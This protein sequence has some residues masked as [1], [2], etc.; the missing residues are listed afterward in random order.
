MRNFNYIY[1][2]LINDN[3]P[4]FSENKKLPSIQIRYNLALTPQYAHI[5]KVIEAFQ[6]IN[7][8]GIYISNIQHKNNIDHIIEEH[9]GPQAPAKKKQLEKIRGEKF[10][11]KTKQSIDELIKSLSFKPNLLYYTVVDDKI[12]FDV[13]KNPS[14]QLTERMIKIVMNNAGIEYLLTNIEKI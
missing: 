10:P 13:D 9:F 11:I 8:Y 2:M 4:S 14:K 1:D 5:D 7:N 3:P 6:N 12:V